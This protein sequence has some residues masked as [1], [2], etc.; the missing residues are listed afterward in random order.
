MNFQSLFKPR[1]MAAIGVSLTN[2]RHP[3]NIIY[4]KTHL[5]YPVKVFPVNPRAGSLSG[6]TVYSKSS[7]IP[8]KID[9]AVVAVRADLVPEV[10]GQ[11]IGLSLA[12]SIGNKALIKEKTLLEYLIADAKTRVI[13]FYIEGFGKVETFAGLI[14]RPGHGS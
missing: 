1:T 8:G 7:E 11:C 14:F 6:E 5:R 9:V 12:V 4:N 2:D 13:A 3:A 10:L